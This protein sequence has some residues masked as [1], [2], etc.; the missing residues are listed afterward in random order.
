M[1]SACVVHVSLS[2][3]EHSTKEGT[4]I[5]ACLNKFKAVQDMIAYQLAWGVHSLEISL[6]IITTKAI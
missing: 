4:Q 6:D 2:V 5:T 1:I 3:D